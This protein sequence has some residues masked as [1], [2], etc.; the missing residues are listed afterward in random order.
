MR[1][2]PW[3]GA[4]PG[5][6]SRTKQRDPAQ[7]GT[8]SSHLCPLPCSAHFSAHE[9]G[10][11]SSVKQQLLPALAGE[12]NSLT[13]NQKH[14]NQ[15]ASVCFLLSEPAAIGHMTVPL[16]SPLSRGP[17]PRAG[18]TD[19]KSQFGSP[20]P[21]RLLQPSFSRTGQSQGWGII[22]SKAQDCWRDKRRRKA[23]ESWARE[24]PPWAG[25]TWAL[26]VCTV[27]QPPLTPSHPRP[28]HAHPGLPPTCPF[29]IIYHLSHVINLLPWSL[30]ISI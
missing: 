7:N 22:S 26:G 13:S 17:C 14:D 19:M 30:P 4:H 2:R 24:P 18:Y 12:E 15:S 20:S 11:V 25:G 3:Q 21:W 9:Q 16:H 29:L 1:W 27:T 10:P 5:K 6:Q 8:C 28:T 23:P